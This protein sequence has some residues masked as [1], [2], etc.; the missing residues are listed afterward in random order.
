M[1]YRIEAIEN[2]E[3]GMEWDEIGVSRI[4]G[5]A[6]LCSRAAGNEL[7]NFEGV[8]WD[9]D[10]D[11]ILSDCRRLGVREFTI[12]NAFSGLI[13]TI[14]S[15]QKNGCTLD[16]VVQIKDRCTPCFKPDEH[17]MIP[18]FKITVNS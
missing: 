16:G 9:S 15:L 5:Q 8:I 17:L 14:D 18:A 11:T 10:I 4:L 6:Y 12:S 13:Q 1:K 7:P 3:N 2:A